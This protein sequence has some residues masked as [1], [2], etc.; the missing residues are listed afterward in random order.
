VV[1]KQVGRGKYG[2]VYAGERVLM[3]TAAVEPPANGGPGSSGVGML[4]GSSSGKFDGRKASSEQDASSKG[5]AGGSS[6]I[7]TVAVAGQQRVAIKI[8]RPVKEHRLR[9][10]IK[11]LGHVRG[12]PNIV[13]L[14][15]VLRDPDTRVS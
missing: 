6:G 13:T 7:G 2:E 3:S 9:R 4:K 8:M 10:E 15:E 1:L 12:H 5:G 11:I 14:L